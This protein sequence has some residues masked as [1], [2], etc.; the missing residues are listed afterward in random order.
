MCFVNLTILINKVDSYIYC[1]TDVKEILPKLQYEDERLLSILLWVQDEGSIDTCHPKAERLN[2]LWVNPELD[3][4]INSWNSVPLP[5]YEALNTAD[6]S[7]VSTAVTDWSAE[8]LLTIGN[9][10]MIRKGYFISE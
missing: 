9:K 4:E 7:I 2:Q 1:P 6:A 5:T 3:G 8:H 10:Q